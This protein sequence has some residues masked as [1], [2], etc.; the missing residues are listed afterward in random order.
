[1]QMKPY[2]IGQGV[3]LFTNGSFLCPSPHVLSPGYSAD[4]AT[5]GLVINPTFLSWKQQDH[6]ILGTLL[7]SFS[8]FPP[9]Y[10]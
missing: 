3:F 9:S 2:L 4:L 7:Y 1:M 6:L 8:E 5:F 10:G